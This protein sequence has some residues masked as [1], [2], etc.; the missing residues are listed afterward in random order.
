VKKLITVALCSVLLLL[1]VGCQKN[2]EQSTQVDELK[3]KYPEY[4]DLATFK[5]IEVYVWQMAENSYT[6]GLLEGTNRAKTADE[7][8]NLKGLSLEDTKT[9]LSVYDIEESDVIIIPYLHPLSSYINVEAAIEDY[10]QAYIE[11]I[12]AMLFS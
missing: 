8:Y 4:F 9:I 11:K 12:R 7:L 1:S 2:N 6:F 3:E 5:G 10:Q